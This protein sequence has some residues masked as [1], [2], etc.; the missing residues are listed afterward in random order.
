M[1]AAAIVKYSAETKMKTIRR[2]NILFWLLLYSK[3]KRDKSFYLNTFNQSKRK[4]TS[5]VM[6]T[7]PPYTLNIE[8]LFLIV[9]EDEQVLSF[10]KYQ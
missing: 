7:R 1:G 9:W 6:S 4:G 10:S 8:S 3:R 5:R 2:E